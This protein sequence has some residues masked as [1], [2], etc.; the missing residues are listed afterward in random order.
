MRVQT[1]VSN[2]QFRRI[3]IAALAAVTILGGSLPSG[4]SENAYSAFLVAQNAQ[5]AAR[6]D[7]STEY[8][9]Q[10]LVIE[11]GN[12]VL[13]S[14]A[15]FA[16]T[17]AGDR[18]YVYQLADQMNLDDGR[19]MDS[20]F[21]ILI[22]DI[23][24]GR[25]DR[26]LQL[27]D[28][29]ADPKGTGPHLIPGWLIIGKGDV[30]DAIDYFGNL[31]GNDTVRRL[32]TIHKAYAHAAVGDF[33]GAL[34]LMESADTNFVSLSTDHLLF[35]AA[36]LWQ[37]SRRTEAQEIIDLVES[38]ASD[39]SIDILIDQILDQEEIELDSLISP[40]K[41]I[42]ELLA[43]ESR[44]LVS[45]NAEFSLYM[46]RLAQ[47]LQPSDENLAFDNA[48][49][50]R[51]LHSYELAAKEYARI[52]ESSPNAYAAEVETARLM[53]LLEE[54]DKAVE[55]LKELTVEHTDQAPAFHLMGDIFRTNGDIE[56]A[57]DSYDKVIAI[58]TVEGQ[59]SWR[60]YFSRAMA[61]YEHN[62]WP[63]TRSDL[64]RALELSDNYHL[65]ANYL[66]Y[67][68][69]EHGENYEE[70]KALIEIALEQDPEN[71]YYLD[72]LGWAYYRMGEF[73][74]AVAPM[75]KAIET[76]PDDPILNDH[77]GDIYWQIGRR[78]EA[79]Y[80]WQRALRN[81]P[82]P[83]DEDAILHKLQ[84]GLKD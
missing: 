64:V 39:P 34:E 38:Y 60:S 1:S 25:F 82:E 54:T 59:P 53:H 84:N 61:L 4:S 16:A 30:V 56:A 43:L 52:P 2:T 6:F 27:Y 19:P 72:S 36:L 73:E 42:A 45:S 83:A 12:P 14:A 79:D 41:R 77:L 78:R 63:E 58:E 46:S 47:F 75:E 22:K 57:L 13:E 65:V 37:A 55:T 50:L 71:A 49:Y 62:R 15:L 69:L 18:N 10:A 76:M 74:A 68:M 51:L 3:S 32:G 21:A 11:P 81:G 48:R 24:Q 33:G 44:S 17:M 80:S 23:D 26:A 40:R 28:R 67:S 9:R 31:E 8:Y 7:V 29:I 66:G 35:H 5:T 20:E 70:A